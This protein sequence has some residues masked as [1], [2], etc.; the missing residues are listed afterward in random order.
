MN[1]KTLKALEGSIVKWE[2][3]VNKKG[4]DD[5]EHNCPLCKLFWEDDCIGCL[6]NYECKGTPYD[7]WL[8]H[9]ERCHQ[10]TPRNEVYCHWC[11]HYAQQELDFLKSLLPKEKP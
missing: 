9:F 3:I 4:I 5:G 6:I 10:N 11:K 2:K 7:D 8:A 1:K